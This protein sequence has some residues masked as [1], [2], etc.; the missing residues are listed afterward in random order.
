[1]EKIKSFFAENKKAL[2]FS[3]IGLLGGYFIINRLNRK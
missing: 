1:M 2:K 3:A